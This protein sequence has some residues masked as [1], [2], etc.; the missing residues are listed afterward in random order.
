MRRNR[1]LEFLAFL[2][3]VAGAVLIMPPLVLIANVKG[4]IV[5]FPP[6]IAFLFAVW[7]FLIFAAYLL[8]RRLALLEP[9]VAQDE[10]LDSTKSGVRASAG[11]PPNQI[12]DPE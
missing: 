4:N 3:P 6:I 11:A 7:A 9:G 2:L 8:Q 5:G 12:G 1:K 10:P